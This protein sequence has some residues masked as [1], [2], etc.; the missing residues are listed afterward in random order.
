MKN[1]TDDEITFLRYIFSNYQDG[2]AI[3]EDGKI[4]MTYTVFKKV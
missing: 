4:S 3:E 2:K 1:L